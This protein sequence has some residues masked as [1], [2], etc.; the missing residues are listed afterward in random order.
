MKNSSR[1]EYPVTQL[2]RGAVNKLLFVKW[3]L[4]SCASIST[5]FSPRQFSLAALVD[6]RI[7]RLDTFSTEV[8]FTRNPPPPPPALLPFT[9]GALRSVHATSCSCRSPFLGCHNTTAGQRSDV[10]GLDLLL[11][12]GGGEE[13]GRG[14]ESRP[15]SER[16]PELRLPQFSGRGVSPRPVLHL[17]APRRG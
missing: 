12:T 7:S 6:G 8:L 1:F 10:L 9:S 5:D 4:H 11:G 2:V 13:R 3:Q 15:R 14:G 17:S 16:L